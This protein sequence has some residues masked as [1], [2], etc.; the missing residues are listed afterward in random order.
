MFA[1]SLVQTLAL[2]LIP[3]F[4]CV[5]KLALRLMTKNRGTPVVR[6]RFLAL[7]GAITKFDPFLLPS[8]TTH[9]RG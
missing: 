6:D 4:Y 9:E 5:K 7:R 8:S 3:L 2:K 1:V